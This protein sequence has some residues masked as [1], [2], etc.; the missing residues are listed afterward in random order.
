MN[1]GMH[2]DTGILKGKIKTQNIAG[3]IVMTASAALDGLTGTVEDKKLQLSEPIQADL[4]LTTDHDIMTV[5]KLDMTSS[6]ASISA[7]G[8]M[9]NIQYSVNANLT[10]LQKELGQFIDM[11]D[12]QIAGELSSKGRVLV[13]TKQ[14]LIQI[15]TRDTVVTDF[16][17]TQPKKK[18]FAQKRISVKLDAVISTEQKTINVKTLEIKS[19]QISIKKAQF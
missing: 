11:G 19:P 4:K 13:N 15:S 14:E 7:S 18:P 10:K 12:G 6:F 3:R 1:K 9:E 8:S 2:I 5:D 17:L 16:I